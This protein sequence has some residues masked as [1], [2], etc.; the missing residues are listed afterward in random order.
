MKNLKKRLSI[1]IEEIKEDEE[2]IQLNQVINESEKINMLETIEYCQGGIK[3][4]EDERRRIAELNNLYINQI[5]YFM[6]N[7]NQPADLSFNW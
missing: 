6:E 2:E 3:A 4:I 5:G 7:E 1:E